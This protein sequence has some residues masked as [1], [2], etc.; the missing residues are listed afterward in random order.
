MIGLILLFL[1]IGWLFF[2]F[3]IAKRLTPGLQ[4]SSLRIPLML[5]IVVVI[6]V[7]PLA[8]EIIGGFQF[9]ALCRENTVLKID[10]E[11]IKGK[12][13]YMVSDSSSNNLQISA[14]PIHLTRV[15]YRDIATHEELASS[16]FLV[17]VGGRLVNALAGG[18][19]MPPL[20]IFPSTCSGPGNLPTSMKYQFTL[21]TT[22][23]GATQ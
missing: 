17:A 8:D 19:Q 6:A 4:T 7:L 3:W 18:H 22:T 9:R 13:I 12:T 16:G 14:I 2:A 15:S 21:D 5:L 23:N 10:A 20:T 1:V 11:K